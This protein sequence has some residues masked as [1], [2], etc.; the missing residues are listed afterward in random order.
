M[1]ILKA[2]LSALRPVFR[3]RPATDN[4]CQPMISAWFFADLV[5]VPDEQRTEQP[6]FPA[7][8]KLTLQ[9][10]LSNN[11]LHPNEH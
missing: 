8:L 2:V 6:S 5:L 4:L 10:K 11:I 3:S 7:K 1:E 9:C